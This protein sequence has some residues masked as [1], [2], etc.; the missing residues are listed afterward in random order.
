MYLSVCARACVWWDFE[1]TDMGYPATVLACVF[2]NVG[3]HAV[4]QT[5]MEVGGIPFN[6]HALFLGEER[7]GYPL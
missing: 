2:L 4:K 3:I 5:F 1:R 6:T 7:S